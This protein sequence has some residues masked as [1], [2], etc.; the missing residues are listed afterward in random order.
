MNEQAL[1][2]QPFWLVRFNDTPI[3]TAAA[4]RAKTIFHTAV[5]MR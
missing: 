4:T 2:N 1:A 3:Q 5:V